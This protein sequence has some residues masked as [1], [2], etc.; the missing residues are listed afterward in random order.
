MALSTLLEPARLR[1]IVDNERRVVEDD[2]FTLPEL[3]TQLRRSAFDGS[4]PGVDRRALHRLLVGQLIQL[5]EKTPPGAPAEASQVA[6]TTLGEIREVAR[7]WRGPR[8]VQGYARAHFE[9][10]DRRITKVL[11]PSSRD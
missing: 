2:R 5:V 7:Y 9:D 8:D 3:F 1:R 10:L 11:D 6:A 4:E